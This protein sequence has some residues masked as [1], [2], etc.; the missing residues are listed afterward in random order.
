VEIFGPVLSV[1]TYHDEDHAVEIANDTTYGL[2]GSIFSTDVYRARRLASWIQARR[3]G[4]NG[5]MEPLPPFGRFK[6]SGI[7]R[8]YGSCGLESFLEPRA[9]AAKRVTSAA[10]ADQSATRS[11]QRRSASLAATHAASA[12]RSRGVSWPSAQAR[13]P[14]VGDAPRSA[15]APRDDTFE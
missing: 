8:E 7:G 9:V 13:H 1:L 4:I 3:V 5:A 14:C 11:S 12:R 6:Q 2:H 10:A 15:K